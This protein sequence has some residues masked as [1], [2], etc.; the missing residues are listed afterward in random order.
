MNKKNRR[1]L[2]RQAIFKGAILKIIFL[3]IKLHYSNQKKLNSE[4]NPKS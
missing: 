4:K 1:S 2:A 3:K